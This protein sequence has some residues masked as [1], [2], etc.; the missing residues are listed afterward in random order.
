[1]D[2]ARGQILGRADVGAI[3]DRQAAHRL[4]GLER[5][6]HLTVNGRQIVEAESRGLARSL[7]DRTASR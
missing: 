7:P 6:D 3:D 5:S 1:M 4:P 2:A